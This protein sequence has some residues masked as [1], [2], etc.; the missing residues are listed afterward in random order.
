M[1]DQEAS[2]DLLGN[3]SLCE[4]KVHHDCL[5]TGLAGTD[6]AAGQ[7]CRSPS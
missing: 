3:V 4:V 1:L 2:S 5:E 7:S 6:P